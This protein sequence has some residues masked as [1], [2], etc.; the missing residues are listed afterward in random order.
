MNTD[1]QIAIIGILGTLGG[2]LLGWFLNVL[3][4][5][6]KLNVFIISWKDD[7]SYNNIG[8]MVPSYNIEKTTNYTYK[9]SM[10][11]YNNSDKTRIMRNIRICFLNDK[12]ILY[13]SI[14]KD[15]PTKKVNSNISFWSYE[16][17]SSINIPPKT[18]LRMYL[19]DS[20][21]KDKGDLDFIWNS[22]SIFLIYTNEKNKEKRVLIKKEDYKNYFINHINEFECIEEQE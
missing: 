13:N 5:R 3:S 17:I 14:P 9:L 6:G 8:C 7:F 21:I 18:V 19:H 10:D 15:D 2:T 1:M 11:L 22:N 20:F 4:Q 12:K 16:N